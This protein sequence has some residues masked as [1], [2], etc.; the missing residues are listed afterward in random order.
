MLILISAAAALI[1][2]AFAANLWL[3]ERM[4]PAAAAL[5][6]GVALL[7][8]FLALLLVH[9]ISSR[10]EAA[11][12][13]NHALREE[14]RRVPAEHDPAEAVSQV[15]ERVQMLFRERPL[16]VLVMSLAAGAVIARYPGA[17]KAMARYLAR[18]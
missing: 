16:M 18:Y 15:T 7:V 11:Q 8:P 2:L 10:A 9:W 5:I 12:E 3:S 4:A 14:A 1:W 13:R 17:A 6:V